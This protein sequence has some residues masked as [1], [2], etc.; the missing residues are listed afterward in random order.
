MFVFSFPG[1]AQEVERQSQRGGCDLPAGKVGIR[2]KKYR[3]RIN[4]INGWSWM[5]RGSRKKQGRKYLRHTWGMWQSCI[6]LCL[7]IPKMGKVQEVTGRE[8]IYNV[9][10]DGEHQEHRT[11]DTVDHDKNQSK[12][13]TRK[14]TGVLTLKLLFTVRSVRWGWTRFKVYVSRYGRRLAAYE[15]SHLSPHVWY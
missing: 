10:N 2:R 8:E 13:P 9:D 7:N 5:K 6:Q 15:P 14:T 3:K 12:Q 11:S 1:Q 4:F